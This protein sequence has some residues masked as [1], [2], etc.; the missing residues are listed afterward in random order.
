[1]KIAILDDYAGV[2]KDVGGFDRIEGAEVSVFRDTLT[3]QSALV[4][5]LLDFDVVCLMRERTPFPAQLIER[6][7][8]LKLL[9]TSG[10]RNLSIDLKAASAR[11]LVVC[12]TESR[13]TTTS[14]FAM[15]LILASSRELIAEHQSMQESGWQRGLGRDLHG[16]SLG[17]I[18]LGKIGT[19]MAKLGQ[20][21]GMTVNAWSTNLTAEACEAQNVTWQPDLKTLMSASDVVS[22][23][24]VLSDRSRGL[25]DAAALG[26]MRERAILV[27]TSRGP[28][29][30]QDDLLNGMKQG[31][32]WKAALDVYDVEPLPVDSGLRDGELV[33]SGRLLL[34]PHLGYVTE[35]TWSIFYTQTVDA[36]LAWQ[37]NKP[38]RVLNA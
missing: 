7:P 27:N 6:L 30:N 4:D 24:L 3:D 29:V 5:R 14:E 10:P 19:Q 9:V 22:I 8:Q 35:Q 33:S 2:A 26:A 15:L 16:L 18:G 37:Q 13:K 32:P 17:L 31:R 1:M 20:A 38:I 34:S 23:H 21:F 12:G 11:G 25:V 28:I 36:I